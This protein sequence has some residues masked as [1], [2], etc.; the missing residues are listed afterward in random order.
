MTHEKMTV[1]TF[2]DGSPASDLPRRNA[3]Q[4]NEKEKETVQEYGR[5]GE[6]YEA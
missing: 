4:A 1:A 5:A 6:E 3:T 2:L